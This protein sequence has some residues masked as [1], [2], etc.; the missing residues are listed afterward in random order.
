MVRIVWYVVDMY[1][2]LSQRLSVVVSE[3]S[4]PD[5]NYNQFVIDLLNNNIAFK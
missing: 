3:I 4:A 2:T 5:F 1:N